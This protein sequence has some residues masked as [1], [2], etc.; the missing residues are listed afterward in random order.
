LTIAL[1][2]IAAANAVK[3]EQTDYDYST[4]SV[5]N[6]QTTYNF[7]TATVS[8]D[9]PSTTLSSIDHYVVNFKGPSVDK[10][11]ECAESPC[12]FEISSIG[13]LQPES[14]YDVLVKPHWKKDFVVPFPLTPAASEY[15]VCSKST[16]QEL[17]NAFA[18]DDEALVLSLLRDPK[19]Q[20]DLTFETFSDSLFGSPLYFA[21]S[22]GFVEIAR[23]LIELGA[24]VN[25]EPNE[26]DHY[27]IVKAPFTQFQYEMVDLLTKAGADASLA[28]KDNWGPLYYAV[29]NAT[30]DPRVFEMLIDAGANCD[31]N[32][33]YLA[34]TNAPDL[35]SLVDQ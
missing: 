34:S 28:D 8:F 1:L 33:K 25:E 35:A 19:C 7:T 12:V 18:F 6:I 14:Q 10:E 13:E 26:Y 5:A 23:E 3:L 17:S 15:N 31:A 9:A 29:S 32:Q 30:Y 20:Y 4:F 2:S 16:H 27:P 24:D 22:R 21:S 11:L